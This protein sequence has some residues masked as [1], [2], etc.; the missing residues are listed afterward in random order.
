MSD[1]TSVIERLQ[2]IL[3]LRDR[4]VEGEAENAGRL[5][6][7]CMKRYGIS[8]ED[9]TD[10]HREWVEVKVPANNVYLK[11]VAN[12][13][14]YTI[15]GPNYRAGHR[16][17][18][19]KLWV[20]LS[21]AEKVEFE[22]MLNLYKRDLEKVLTDATVAFIYRND[23]FPVMDAGADSPDKEKTP[24]EE[25]RIKRAVLMMQGIEKTVM[26]KQIGSAGKH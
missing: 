17:G 1:R 3:A 13:L 10:E 14:A 15:V 4:G 19:K 7:A 6:D 21:K 24:E 18:S 20:M 26:R 25:E 16:N 11:K 5:L 22:I 2:K 23:I 8:I 12:Q 9:L